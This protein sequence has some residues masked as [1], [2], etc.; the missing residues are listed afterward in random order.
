M[1][2]GTVIVTVSGSGAA[3]TA[4]AGPKLTTSAETVTVTTDCAAEL[5][6]GR[7]TV[8]AGT[9]M[10]VVEN[11]VDSVT[12]IVRGSSVFWEAGLAVAEE[13][14]D[15]ETEPRNEELTGM[16]PGRAPDVTRT[17]DALAVLEVTVIVTTLGIGD[18]L[19]TEIVAC[20]RAV[21]EQLDLA[22]AVVAGSRVVAEHVDLGSTAVAS[23]ASV[24][25]QVV[26]RALSLAETSVARFQ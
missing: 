2:L 5:G 26:S 21:V 25:E 1:G 10:V 11:A 3:V 20:P 24:L 23:T 6:T 19:V 7:V 16:K 14:Q 4:A 12:M 9:L 22:T 18:D 17:E 8:A 13:V 15:D